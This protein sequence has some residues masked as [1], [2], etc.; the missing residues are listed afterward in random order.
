[1]QISSTRQQQPSQKREVA[2][3]AQHP[4]AM[5]PTGERAGHCRGSHRCQGYLGSAWSQKALETPCT[6]S[7]KPKKEKVDLLHG[8]LAQAG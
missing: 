6:L 2:I 8:V 5:A 4:Q 3:M 7:G 1:M